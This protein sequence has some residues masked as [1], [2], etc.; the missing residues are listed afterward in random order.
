MAN[1]EPLFLHYNLNKLN[2][3]P[4]SKIANDNL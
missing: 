3:Q 4:I 2:F 1:L